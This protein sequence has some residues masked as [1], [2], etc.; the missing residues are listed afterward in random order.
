MSPCSRKDFLRLATVGGSAAFFARN[1]VVAAATPAGSANGNIR[2]AI[3][4]VRSRGSWLMR[5]FSQIPGVTLVALCDVDTDVLALRLAQM[6]E[7]GVRVAAYAD[8]RNLVEDSSIDAVV[9]ATPNH[10]HALMAIWACQAGKDVYLEKPISHNVWEGRK[11]IDAARKYNRIVQTG[12][13][14][15]SDVALA[16]AFA[17]IRSGALGKIKWVRGLCYK[18]RASIGKT[19]GPQPVPT[20]I[21]YDLWTGPAAFKPPR[22]NT[23]LGTVH[24]DWHWF[25]N[26]GGGDIANQGLHELDMCRWALG[27]EGLPTSVLSF[28]GRFGYVDDAETPNTQVAVYTYARAPLIFEVRGLPRSSGDKTMDGYR[29]RPIGLVVQCEHGYFAGGAGGGAIH[30]HGGNMVKEFRGPGGV[31][32]QRNFIAAVRSRKPSDLA[33]PVEAGHISAALSHLGNIS[34]RLGRDESN[35]AIRETIAADAEA[36]DSF[37]RMMDHLQANEVDVARTATMMGPA[38]TLAP[39]SERF[40]TKEKS[41][42]GYWANAMLRREYRAPFIVPDK[43]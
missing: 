43:V 25:W 7:K 22:R 21:D 27:E 28:G 8:Y 18:G 38:L 2:V 33:A 31:E 34:Y 39:G 37:A 30:D 10:W 19:S 1:R 12:T 13:Q 23:R 20:Q 17:E 36:Q 5:E 42:A 11:I 6:A 16:E 3:V 14:S 29:G 26:Y 24:Y 9:I 32:H 4:G 35:D 40:V 15:R 41:D